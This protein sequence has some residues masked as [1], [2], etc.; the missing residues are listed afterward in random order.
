MDRAK[1]ELTKDAVPTI[2]PNIPKFLSSRSP[3]SR[4]HKIRVIQGN[5][6]K[7]NATIVTTTDNEQ[8]NN[9]IKSKFNRVESV[10][11]VVELGK[12]KHAKVSC[13]SCRG[14]FILQNDIYQLKRKVFRQQGKI[15]KLNTQVRKLLVE[16]RTLKRCLSSL[17]KSPPKTTVIVDQTLSNA[18]VK[19]KYGNRYSTECTLDALLIRCKSTRAYRMLRENQYLPLPSISTLNRN[20]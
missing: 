10:D 7:V 13:N 15:R 11:N 16:N 4:K 2:F 17:D 20:I 12:P 1:W 18:N 14:K 19:L 3:K 6:G 8:I 9:V 5:E